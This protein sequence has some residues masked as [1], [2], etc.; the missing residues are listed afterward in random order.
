MDF[1]RF[2]D[3]LRA[4]ESATTNSFRSVKVLYRPTDRSLHK[5]AISKKI[6]DKPRIRV[7]PITDE[8]CIQPLLNTVGMV[9]CIA[10]Q[11]GRGEGIHVN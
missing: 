10:H 5:R 4:Y 6:P 9:L 8:T 7:W 11:G 3:Y 1:C 2:S